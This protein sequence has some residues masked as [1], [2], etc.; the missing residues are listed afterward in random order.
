MEFL[1]KILSSE[2]FNQLEQELTAYNNSKQ[3]DA[4]KV[5]LA[6]LSS[7]EYVGKGK[8]TDLETTLAGKEKELVSANKLIA[9]LKK[10]NKDNETLQEQI[11]AHEEE[12]NR[13]KGENEALRLK[14]A[15]KVALL[16]SKAKDADYLIYKLTEEGAELKLDANGNVTNWDN[17]LKDLKVKF[18]S[19]FEDINGNGGF[20]PLGG[21]RLPEGGGGQTVTKEQFIKMGYDERVKLKE[22]NEELYRQLAGK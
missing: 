7:G 13:L 15:V 6:N 3:D 12:I 5:K 1:K 10:G 8:Y 4:E 14:S 2:L 19:M 18:P 17:H 16:E 11:K 20:E 22:E 21:G 9:S